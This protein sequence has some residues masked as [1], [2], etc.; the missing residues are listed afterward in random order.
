MGQGILGAIPV[1]FRF[2]KRH[3][4][5]EEENTKNFKKKSSKGFFDFYSENQEINEKGEKENYYIIK[6]EI[7]LPNFKNFFIEFHKII[8]NESTVEFE[9]TEKF[10]SDYDK[11]V[12]SG[13]LDEFL[14]HFD[15][16]SGSAPTVFEYFGTMYIDTSGNDL[17]VYQ[18]SYK[19]FLE[20]W[21]TL[22]HM[23]Y[24]VRAA[25]SNPLAQVIKF[26]M[27]R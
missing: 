1:S 17:L 27:S 6:P 10:N 9:I 18:G 4:Y 22:T 8:G 7:L 14:K 13:N 19:A 21:S 5:S 16:N 25:V 15:D 3:W 23:E 20:V 26:G 12:A 11:A 2:N 24:L